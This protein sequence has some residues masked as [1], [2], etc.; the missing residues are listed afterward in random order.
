MNERGRQSL[1]APQI[2][3]DTAMMNTILR[4]LFLSLCL[5]QAVFA[6]TMV[7]GGI[8]NN[9]T[10]SLAGSPYIVTNNVVVFPGKT[11]TI[12]PGVEV[13]VQGD[14]FTVAGGNLIEVRGNLVAVGTATAP[15][16][17][18]ADAISNDPHTWSGILI[19]AS[20]GGDCEINYVHMSNMFDGLRAD[21]Y[22][23][24]GDTTYYNNCV[25]TDNLTALRLF[26]QAILRDCRFAN[27]GLAL[28]GGSLPKLGIVHCD[29]DSNAV[30]LG[31]IY[32]LVTIDSSNFRGNLKGLVANNPGAVTNCFFEGNET[33]VLGIGY[34][35]SNCILLNNQTAV[36]RLEGGSVTNCTISNNNL[37]VE[38]IAGGTLVNNDI[39]NND[40]GVKIWDP[41][42]DFSGNRICGNSQYNVEN[43][44]DKNISLVGNCFCESDSTIAE[45]LLF[46][47]YDDITRGLFNY[48]LYDSSCTNIVQL[49]SKVS[50]PTGF[51]AVGSEP[52]YV[53]PN[54]ASDVLQVQL[55]AGNSTG[56]IKILNLQGQV[57][58]IVA[59]EALTRIEVADLAAGVYFLDFQGADRQVVKWIKQ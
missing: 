44:A 59:A 53:Y 16:T 42:V 58:R 18:K 55:P 10:W 12:E 43:Q 33:G 48:A 46:D 13:R 47:G 11:L 5:G 17:F 45:A 15:I 6:Q 25:F 52:I 37:G 2:S 4:V 19:K 50:I 7:S 54:P 3:T 41:N 34:A 1:P 23:V 40:I 20:Q 29:F 57:L 28:T 14:L 56:E 27:N 21:N 51:P 35:L 49:I 8:Y 31:Y 22:T 26:K 32:H 38:L 30:G 36:G 39:G 9:V 24:G